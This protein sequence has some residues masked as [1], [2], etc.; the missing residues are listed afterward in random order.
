MN[1]IINGIMNGIRTRG[2]G[3]ESRSR[4]EFFSGHF[5]I[6]VMAAFASFVPPGNS[7]LVR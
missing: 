6:S 5:S 3:F 2:R 4:P 7:H 1:G